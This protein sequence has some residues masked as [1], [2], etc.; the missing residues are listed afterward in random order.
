VNNLGVIYALLSQFDEALKYFSQY[1]EF[2]R[3]NKNATGKGEH[4]SILLNIGECQHKLGRH[5]SAID[6][7]QQA[8]ELQREM[9]D[10]R[11]L[12]LSY[13]TLG[14]ICRVTGRSQEA[15]QH[16]ESAIALA[17]EIK[18]EEVLL[19]PLTGIATLWISLG[20]AREATA[21]ANEARLLSERLQTKHWTEKAWLLVARADSLKGDHR[22]AARWLSRYIQ[23]HDS[24]FSEQK[25]KLVI[26]MRELYETEKKESEI[27]LLSEARKFEELKRSSERNIFMVTL[28]F[29]ALAIAGAVYWAIMKTKHSR[30]LK[31]R[32]DTI[33]AA[34]AATSELLQKIEQQNKALAAKNEILQEL[35]REKDGLIGVVAHDLRSPLQRIEGLSNL[36]KHLGPLVAEQEQVVD[37]IKKVCR[38][39]SGLIRDLLDINQYET[40]KTLDLRDTEITHFLAG[41][42]DRYLE[43][44]R[45]KQLVLHYDYD[46]AHRAIMHTDRECLIRV[47]DN[48][49]T[50][51]IK[52]SQPHRNIYLKVVFAA[53]DKVKIIL[54]DEG[55]GFHPDDLPHLFKKFKKLTAR[56]T[57][58]ESSSGLGLSIVKSLVERLKGEIN[59]INYPGKGAEFVLTFNAIVCDADSTLVQSMAHEGITYN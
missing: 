5:T 24:L 56:P 20:R 22:S 32:N 53:E 23:L 1:Y 49:L 57:A 26:R 35:H 28:S 34:H 30:M 2:I 47:I 7:L 4:A 33:A 16:Y 43:W 17:R 19:H 12:A 41:V 44:I 15:V 9:N 3:Q 46:K 11:G 52:F 40:V 50:N 45:N 37:N 39:G 14:D 59:L 58:G 21:S 54:R 6:I 13:S 10:R 8:V 29:L 31:T 48:L 27:K 25:S 36:L 18:N 42:L 55:P 51:A 38:D